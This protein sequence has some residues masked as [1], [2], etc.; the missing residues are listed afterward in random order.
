MPSSH[1]ESASLRVEDQGEDEEDSRYL[2]Q[3]CSISSGLLFILCEI[4]QCQLP[5]NWL[6][7]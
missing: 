1:P 5:D 3:G 4:E 2:K 6:Q 7:G